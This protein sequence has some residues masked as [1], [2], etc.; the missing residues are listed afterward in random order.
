MKLGHFLAPHIKKQGTR[1]LSSGFN[2]SEQEAASKVD[3]VLTVTAG[4][5]EGFSTI[6]RGLES[7]ASI[8]GKNI[9]DNSVKII[10]HK[11]VPIRCFGNPLRS[12]KNKIMNKYNVHYIQTYL[13]F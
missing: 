5:V 12:S 8:L 9:K 7:S 2:L 13:S 3:G 11:W 4:A 1:L 10:E 6:Y